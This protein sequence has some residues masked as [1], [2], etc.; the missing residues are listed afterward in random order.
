LFAAAALLND[1]D[2]AGLQLLNGGDVLGE[3]THLS[4]LGGNVD[5]YAVKGEYDGRQGLAD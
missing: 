5:L 1:L 4:G 3:D 2:E